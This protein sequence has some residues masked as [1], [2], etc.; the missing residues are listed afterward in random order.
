MHRFLNVRALGLALVGLMLMAVMGWLGWWQFTVYDQ[1][2]RADAQAALR[3]PPVPLSTVIGPDSAFPADGVG[4]PVTVSGT[5]LA[6]QQIYVRNL[7][8][9]THRY[10]VVTPLVTSGGSAILVVRGSHDERTAAAPAGT[11]SVRGV[12]EPSVD[13][14]GPPNA[15]RIADGLSVSA[16]VGAVGPDLYSG[17]L[18]QQSSTPAQ[19]PALSPVP[20]PLPD[21]SRWSGVR[22]LLYACQWWVFAGFVAFMWWRMTGDLAA[23]ARKRADTPDADSGSLTPLR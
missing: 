2:Q 9:A 8:G 4:R 16:L 3:Q 5:F 22:N 18:L 13:A 19:Q 23:T 21:P 6:G 7:P 10:A 12:L 20:P 15:Q 1:H 17:Y 11:V 14:G